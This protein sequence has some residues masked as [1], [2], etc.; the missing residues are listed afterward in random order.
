MATVHN[1]YYN[2]P[3]IADAARNLASAL[4]PPDP[5]KQLAAKRGQWEF[6]RLQQLAAIQDTDRE[7]K[8]SFRTTTRRCCDP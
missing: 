1:A 8:G 3:W 2:S 4:A 5:E 7:N 6:D